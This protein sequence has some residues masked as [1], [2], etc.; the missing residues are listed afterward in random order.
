M[1][2]AAAGVDAGSAARRGRTY[3]ANAALAWS[4][5]GVLQRGLTV[6]V[7]T[8]VAGRAFFAVLALL[9]YVCV[10]ERGRPLRGFAAI[11][12]DG[13]AIAVLMAISSGSFI[14][15]LN[16]TSVANVLVLQ[17]LSPLIAAALGAVVLHEAVTRRTLVAMGLAVV[18]VAVMVGSPGHA[19]ALGEGLAFLMSLSFA[20]AI[21]LIRRS[22][23]VSMAPA[24]CL[25]QALLLVCFAPFAQPDQIGGHDLLL[26]FLFGFAQIGLA[27]IFLMSGARLIPAGEVALISLLEVVLGP[28][29]VWIAWSEKP[30]TATLV[31]GAIVLLGVLFQI[32]P[33][34]TAPE[35]SVLEYPL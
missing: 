26:L 32:R 12:R 2:V 13:I 28:L 1:Q 33:S 9:A 22:R 21:V 10:V 19:D 6:G 11:G 14:V 20:A 17:A 7:P 27:L 24:T 29:W 35:E 23:S 18:G 16:H 5:A 34:A 31:G 8:Q 3:D 4:S 15:A 30:S 25:S